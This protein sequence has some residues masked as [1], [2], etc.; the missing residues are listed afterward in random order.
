MAYDIKKFDFEAHID[1]IG[2]IVRSLKEGEI[3]ILT[4]PN[5]Y[6]KSLL[7]KLT[8]N[9]FSVKTAS[10]SMERRTI[11]N[12]DF[13]AFST[14][15]IDKAD[16]ATSNATC[17][18]VL[19]LMKEKQ[20]YLVVDEP[21]IGMGKEMLLGLIRSMERKIDEKKK[22][23]DWHGM[24]IITHSEFLIENMKHDRFINMEGKT[25]DE[26]KN[27]DIVA[28]DPDELDDWC[29]AMWKAIEN[30]LKRKQDEA[31]S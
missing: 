23:D 26:W 14:L 13:S 9:L 31:R 16:D 6:G 30:R 17:N 28:I 21:E 20:R 25:Y 10:V 1:R 19:D 8:G 24:L 11:P 2:E 29:H 3:T 22:E 7:R 15:A 4:G 5:G 18:L 27:R 12:H